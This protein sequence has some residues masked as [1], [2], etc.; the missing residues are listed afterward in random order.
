MRSWAIAGKCTV[1]NIAANFF[2]LN[3]ASITKAS[4]KKDLKFVLKGIAS[5]GME[6]AA[7]VNI[8]GEMV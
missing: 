1:P 6:N 4:I 5:C 2:N 3:T 8:R 7:A